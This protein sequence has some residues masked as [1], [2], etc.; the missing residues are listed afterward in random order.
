MNNSAVFAKNYSLITGLPETPAKFELL[1]SIKLGV[2]HN[3]LSNCN[4]IWEPT[5]STGEYIP[6]IQFPDT[7]FALNSRYA[8]RREAEKIANEIEYSDFIL[9]IGFEGGYFSEALLGSI[10]NFKKI[11][12]LECCSQVIIEAMYHRDLSFLTDDRFKLRIVYNIDEIFSIVHSEYQTHFFSSIKIFI[13]TA[14]KALYKFL[15]IDAENEIY[16]SVQRLQSD[17]LTQSHLGKRW[18]FN[19]AN[20]FKQMFEKPQ[21]SLD[22]FPEIA[23]LGAG[24]GLEDH[25]DKIRSLQKKGVPILACDA[26]F[27]WCL[28]NS[29]KIHALLSIDGQ[30]I[31]YL[32]LLQVRHGKVIA[33]PIHILDLCS[34]PEYSRQSRQVHFRASGHPLIQFF[35]KNGMEILSLNTDG[36]NVGH[37]L[38][39]VAEQMGA[40]IIHAFGLDF[41][42]KNGKPYVEPAF[43]YTEALRKAHRLKSYEQTVLELWLGQKNTE[44]ASENNIFIQTPRMQTYAL[45]FVKGIEKLSCKVISYSPSWATHIPLNSFKQHSPNGDLPIITTTHIDSSDLIKTYITRLRHIG[46]ELHDLEKIYSAYPSEKRDLLLSLMPLMAWY[47]AF[48]LKNQP[49]CTDI[50]IKA[51]DLAIRHTINLLSN[52]FGDEELI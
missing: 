33:N 20:N 37:S 44:F 52:H 2:D 26:S 34:H 10:K 38:A 9:L 17:F 28:Q 25:I 39:F 45:D 47:E 43:F 8:P 29:I 48:I 40:D 3:K 42:Y 15:K 14:Y 7:Q 32:H 24:P 13:S 49:E 30:T 36:G 35:Q 41:S 4:I 18:L 11:L 46:T 50:P 22:Q 5:R 19:I 1:Q 51:I 16:S 6:I 23:I 31:S 21:L 12:C 27:D